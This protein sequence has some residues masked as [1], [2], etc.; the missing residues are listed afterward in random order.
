MLERVPFLIAILGL[1]GGVLIAIFFG[2]NEDYFKGTIDRAL[3]SNPSIAAITDATQR[4]S[5]IKKEAEK[6]WRYYQRY[7]FHATG[8]G[9]MSLGL[10]IVLAMLVGARR[11]RL[12]AAYFIS[13]GGAL[14]PFV[15]LFA[16][17]YGPSIGRHAAKERFAIFGYMGGLFLVG[18]LLC[19][20]L[21]VVL[22]FRNR[23][24]SAT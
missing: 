5:T 18:A 13:I 15:W 20:T 8:I 2:V 14:Y 23:D 1:C 11:A 3:Q 22:P 16:A 9:A 21:V 19:A 7:H 6:N 4:K 12:L 10:L 17:I 24:E